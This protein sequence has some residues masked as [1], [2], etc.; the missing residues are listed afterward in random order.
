[1]LNL[2]SKLLGLGVAVVSSTATAQSALTVVDTPGLFAG[3][4]TPII[5]N[6]FSPFAGVTLYQIDA[7]DPSGG[8]FIGTVSGSDNN[9]FRS[10]G[11]STGVNFLDS[12]AELSFYIDNNGAGSFNEGAQLGSDNWLYFSRNGNP[13]PSFHKASSWVQFEFTTTSFTVL[14]YVH[15]PSNPTADISL[16]DAV[17]AVPE[18]S[19]LSLFGFGLL[20]LLTRRKRSVH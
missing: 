16:Q 10:T 12:T 14:R 5:L 19:S 7:T 2:K 1:M 17:N 20:G 18:P 15:D 3:P 11:D 6:V 9:F 4:T 8:S 13:D